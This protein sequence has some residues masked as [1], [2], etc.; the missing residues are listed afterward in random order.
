MHIKKISAAGR[1][2]RHILFI[3]LLLLF[4]NGCAVFRPKKVTPPPRPT[5]AKPAEVSGSPPAGK[6][7]PVAKPFREERYIETV[8]PVKER[9]VVTRRPAGERT[10]EARQSVEGSRALTSPPV[11]R[12]YAA[13]GLPGEERP[14]A[15]KRPGN[16]AAPPVEERPDAIEPPI[17][18]RSII[19]SA[20]K[21]AA[22]PEPAEESPDEESSVV[23]QSVAAYKP[24]IGKAA[25]IYREAEEAM[26]A[27]NYS[28]AELLLERALRVEPRNAHYWYTLGLAKFRQKKYP[29]AVQFCLKAE[30]LAGSQPGLMARNQVL[31]AQAKKAAGAA[32]AR[33]RKPEDGL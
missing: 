33:N 17:E 29:Q 16:P 4:L 19:S 14:V 28:S 6:R 5:A 18:E 25:A 8:P 20:E 3:C 12:E 13:P 2:G 27:E 10:S 9:S 26:Q 32:E 15:V 11:E 23:S 7:F 1:F 22:D 21:R 30:S 31:L 24:V